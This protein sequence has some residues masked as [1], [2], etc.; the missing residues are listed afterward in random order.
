KLFTVLK[1]CD[2]VT[3]NR[4]ITS[5]RGREFADIIRLTAMNTKVSQNIIGPDK[6][7]SRAQRTLSNSLVK[8]NFECIGTSQTDDEVGISV[9]LKEFGRLIANIE[10]QRD[11]M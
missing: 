1:N 4:S 10:D 7:L 2:Y 6:D 8:F 5:F 3:Q 11:M 9:S